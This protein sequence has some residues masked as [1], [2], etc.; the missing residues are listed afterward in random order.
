VATYYVD[1]LRPDDTGDGLSELTAWRSLAKVTAEK[2]VFLANDR[3][4]LRR[5]GVWREELKD[6]ADAVI[7]EPFGSG[8]APRIEGRDVVSSWV[9]EGA[10]QWSAP[11]AADPE[12]V[13]FDGVRGVLVADLPS[14]AAPGDWWWSAGDLYT[15]AV[16]GTPSAV[17]EASVRTYCIAGGTSGNVA[18]N[19][20]LDGLELAGAKEDGLGVF[21]RTG[22]TVRNA[23]AFGCERH[24]FKFHQCTSPL[25]EDSEAD[26]NENGTDLSEC[27]AFK[28][29]RNDLHDNNRDAA[30][31]D[32]IN[33]S[34][35][36]GQI[37]GNT[38]YGHVG[39]SADGIQVVACAIDLKGNRVHDNQNGD[40]VITAGS[41]GAI[42]NNILGSVG[43]SSDSGIVVQVEDGDLD[44]DHN[45]FVGP[46]SDY[47]IKVNSIEAGRA[48][49]IRGNAAD[50]GDRALSVAPSVDHTLIT[51]DRNVW[52]TAGATLIFWENTTYAQAAFATY[53]AVTGTPDANSVA[54]D[55][56]YLDASA[57]NFKPGAASPTASLVLDLGYTEDYSGGFRPRGANADAGAL[58]WHPDPS[59]QFGPV[60]FESGDP[61]GEFDDSSSNISGLS[62][63]AEAAIR[64]ATGMAIQPDGTTRYHGDKSVIWN[65]S[66]TLR[67]GFRFDPNGAAFSGGSAF[68]LLRSQNS[69]LKLDL[70]EIG[71]AFAFKVRWKDDDST[72]QSSAWIATT[73]AQLRVELEIKRG[74]GTGHVKLIVGGAEVW[75]QLSIN[76]DSTTRFG[77]LELGKASSE[78]ISLDVPVYVDDWS[79]NDNGEAIFPAAEV[80]NLAGSMSASA[81]FDGVMRREMDLEGELEAR[82]RFAGELENEDITVYELAGTMSAAAEFSQ[83]GMTAESSLAGVMIARAELEATLAQ[84]PEVFTFS[85]LMAGRIQRQRQPSPILQFHELE[86][87]D[88]T[89]ARYVDFS[90]K[91]HHGGGLPGTVKYDG[92]DYTSAAIERTPISK[93]A[94][95]RRE[96]FSL[97][98]A[99][100]RYEGAALLAE[101]NGLRG[102]PLSIYWIPYD[103]IDRPESSKHERFKVVS[104]HLAQGP[105]GISLLIGNPDLFGTPFPRIEYDAHKCWNSFQDRHEPGA[106]C[107]YPAN[108]FGPSTDQDFRVGGSA[109]VKKR[110]FGW[111]TQQALR[112]S[113]FASG[114]G[115]LVVKTSSPDIRWAGGDRYGPQFFRSFTAL[116]VDFSTIADVKTANKPGW[117]PG[118]IVQDEA[119]ASPDD[120]GDPG[121]PSSWVIFGRAAGG[122]VRRRLTIADV[123]E[124]YTAPGVGGGSPGFPQGFRI[125]RVS[126]EDF[127]LYY[128]TDDM[129][130][131]AW[132]LLETVT[133]TGLGLAVRCGVVVSA[134]TAGDSSL[135]HVEFPWIRFTAGGFNNCNRLFAECT[136]REMLHRFS[137]V[138]GMA[139]VS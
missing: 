77:H 126:Q 39:A 113:E 16:G 2:G 109:Q 136:Q 19:V 5:G 8:V 62:F 61:F 47:A 52:N 127:E 139:G 11:L 98:V 133:V 33:V 87:P 119:P 124:D 24:G 76:L 135:L 32:G 112:S 117:F 17:I 129:A 123:S 137:A 86:L 35:G 55:P 25:L 91:E 68:T 46:Y 18:N 138:R 97:T 79:A 128:R 120:P 22:W 131:T 73:D 74:A 106:H 122:T 45:S 40:V 14:V 105:N 84:A 23:R 80:V 26:D 95:G 100:P 59:N 43:G 29:Y 42:Y 85:D 10:D 67:T 30:L 107:N 121:S 99:D 125:R 41:S 58:E 71:G 94:D 44:I 31:G 78:D 115:A 66:D 69:K 118:L 54:G 36:D 110:K 82:G 96:R 63:T 28:I 37:H 93:G 102:Q 104:S 12:Q 57:E 75:S 88:G 81:N 53:Q 134:D 20:I 83:S 56:L 13:F 15:Y 65:A 72:A 38:I 89:F 101:N 51:T 1:D 111:S 34:S 116:D 7:L 3:I 48:L 130:G 49:R 9:S 50:V 4:Q 60:D 64:G 27:T 6:L 70:Q 132:E 114:G 92:Q 90:D 21:G 103:A 108:E